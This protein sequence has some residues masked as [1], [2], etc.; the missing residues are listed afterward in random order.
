MNLLEVASLTEDQSREYFEAIR[1]PEGAVCPHCKEADCKRMEGKKHRKGCF[2]CNNKECR[3]QFTVRNGSVLESSKVPY[4][5]WV[6]AF[7]L[8]CSSKKGFAAKQL[9]R[10]LDLGSYRTAWFM[11]HRIRHAMET[12]SLEKPLVGIVEVDETFVGGKPRNPGE[13]G[14]GR[15]TNK[16]PVMVLVERDGRAV[17]GPIQRLT[18][19]QLK[20]PIRKYVGRRAMIMTDELNAYGGLYAEFGGHETVNHSQKQYARK[21]TDG[22]VVHSNTAESFFALVKRGHYGVY[23][24]MSKP[25][26]HR[27]CA[28]FA[29]RW[30]Y[31]KQ[32][33]GVRRDAL[34]KQISGKRLKY[35]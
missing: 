26:I 1:W 7:H 14:R 16:Q 32:N 25:H 10:E 12:Q 24:L 20:A 23:H 17:C 28:E 22:L 2:Q 9:Q 4:K 35:A 31:R 29:F 18:A 33:D 11:L 15:G 5:K 27:Y 6:L 21:R 34:I 19:D 30:N 3:G 8:L 13:S